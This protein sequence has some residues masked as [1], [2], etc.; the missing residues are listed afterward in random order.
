MRRIFEVDLWEVSIVV[1]PLLAG[2]RV[3]AAKDRKY[4]PDQPRVP[5]GNP[6]GGQWTSG[7][8][9]GMRRSPQGAKP[10][11]DV[12][13]AQGDFGIQIAE[14][15]VAGGRRCVY[16]FSAF[17]VVVAGAANFD[18]LRWRIGLR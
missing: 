7:S 5:A 2:A 4:S 15:P 14:I 12:V 8:G 3:S 17:S 16:R 11:D 1:F 13:L 9:A 6:D 10:R 18:A